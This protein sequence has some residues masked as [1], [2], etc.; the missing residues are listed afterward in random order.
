MSVDWHALGNDNW[1][2][3]TFLPDETGV[4]RYLFNPVF[5]ATRQPGP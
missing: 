3:V 2:D 1:G 4:Y 5:V